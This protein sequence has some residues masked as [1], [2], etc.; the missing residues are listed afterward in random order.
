M[1]KIFIG[2]LIETGPNE[3]TNNKGELITTWKIAVALTE[4]KAQLFNVSKDHPIYRVLPD[5]ELGTK[6]KCT[7][8]SHVKPD[9][10]IIWKLDNLEQAD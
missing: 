4:E 5:L 2:E 7:A 1:Q 3:W 8:S 9:G 6:L 10:R